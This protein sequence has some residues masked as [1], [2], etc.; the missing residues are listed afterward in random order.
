M[1]NKRV[2]R[3][4]AVCMFIFL[5]SRAGILQ[6]F[7]VHSFIEGVKSNVIS[8]INGTTFISILE[9]LKGQGLITHSYCFSYFLALIGCIGILFLR[10]WAVWLLFLYALLEIVATLTGFHEGAVLLLG[11]ERKSLIFYNAQGI[12]LSLIIFLY[13]NIKSVREQLK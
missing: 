12:L 3:L 9:N 4:L 10:K 2:I 7:I 1:Y 11:V 8:L 6:I 5:I 13:F